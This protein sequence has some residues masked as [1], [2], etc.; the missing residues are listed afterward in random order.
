MEKTPL[1]RQAMCNRLAMEFQNDW[2]VNLGIGM[3]TLCSNYDFGET[4]LSNLFSC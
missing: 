3:P 2:V 4:K 1:T